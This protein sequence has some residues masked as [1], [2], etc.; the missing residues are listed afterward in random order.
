MKHTSKKQRVKPNPGTEH[1][2]DKSTGKLIPMTCQ[3]TAFI[4]LNDC[5]HHITCMVPDDPHP[6][7]PH[8]AKLTQTEEFVDGFIGWWEMIAPE[9]ALPT[10]R[11]F[12]IEGYEQP[13]LSPEAQAKQNSIRDTDNLQ[14]LLEALDDQAL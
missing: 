2:F 1:L 10:A 13:P 11:C 7:Q 5:T 3:A 9:D 6:N 8:M 12:P 4:A 14:G